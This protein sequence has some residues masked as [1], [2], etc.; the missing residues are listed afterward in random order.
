MPKGKF[1][2]TKEHCKNIGLAQM[3]KKHWNW[4][5]DKV[6]YKGLHDWVSRNYGKP[7]ICWFCGKTDAKKFEWANISGKY[8]RDKCDWI[9][10]CASCHDLFERNPVKRKKIKLWLTKLI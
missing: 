1:I 2:R 9:R 8:L 10:L 4:K 3:G 7:H 5:G 6:G